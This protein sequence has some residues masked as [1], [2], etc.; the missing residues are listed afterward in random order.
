MKSTRTAPIVSLM[1]LAG[2]SVTACSSP[3][4]EPTRTATIPRS[5][6]AT[7]T[8]SST[9]TTPPTTPAAAEWTPELLTDVCIDFQGD[10]AEENSYAVDDFTWTSPGTTQQSGGLW[11]VFLEGTFTPEGGEAVPAE[12]SCAISGTPGAPVIEESPGE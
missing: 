9:P 3:A 10:W 5:S 2:L 12:F 11:Y 6:S 8:P 7:P 4:P 1:L